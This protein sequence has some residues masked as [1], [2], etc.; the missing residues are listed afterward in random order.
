M[1]RP[2]VDAVGGEEPC[3]KLSPVSLQYDA[4]DVTGNDN[5][6]LALEAAHHVVL[7]QTNHTSETYD[8]CGVH[9]GKRQGAMDYVT[10]ANHWQIPLHK[11][12]NTVKQTMQH[13]VHTDLH[14]TSSRCFRTNNRML[15]Y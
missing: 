4:A 10:L 1:G 14:L 2:L 7:V 15:H 8:V 11:A 3:W 5:F 9:L 6:G 12:E 13:G